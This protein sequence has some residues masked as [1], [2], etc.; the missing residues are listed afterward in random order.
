MVAQLV[1]DLL[2]LEDRGV[3]LDEAGRADRALRDAQGVLR[4]D[5]HGVPQTGLEV[6]L[7]LG[8]VE[9]RAAT[10]RDL[11][12]TGGREVQREVDQRAGGD[13]A[14]D[15]EVLLLEVPAAGA[16]DDGRQLLVGAQRVRLALLGHEVDLA[17]GRVQEVDLA[18]DDGV[19]RG[20][21]R[22][23]LVGQPDLRAGVERVDR[24]L[25][26]RGAGHLDAA[27]LEA[28]RGRGD[29]PRVVLADR[30]R[31]LEE[32]ELL[33]RVQAG[34][35]VGARGEALLAR[36]GEGAVQ[37]DDELQCLRG[38]DLLRALGQRGRD[39]EALGQLDGRV[40]HVL[41]LLG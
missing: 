19:P 29:L 35:A 41:L 26:V 28:G 31:L 2:H 38:E 17:A 13:L 36:P 21:V 12:P 14:V 39:L 15:Q 30:A 32:V 9:V 4:V 27:V 37:R 7:H 23:L 5:E 24:H 25:L 6:R 40:S 20:R 34:L 33:T 10:L 22:V 16:H 18:A 8:Q 3:G 1:E 11:L